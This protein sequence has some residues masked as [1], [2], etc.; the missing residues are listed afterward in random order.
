ME[1][2]VWKFCDRP[3]KPS[4]LAVAVSENKIVGLSSNTFQKIKVG[5]NLY[6]A[7][8]GTDAAVEPEYRR[9]G[10]MKKTMAL[11]DQ[12]RKDIG[13]A[14]TW[15]FTSNPILINMY[16]KEGRCTYPEKIVQLNRI[17]DVDKHVKNRG[18]K[19]PMLYSLGISTLK[20]I[21]SLFNFR[22]NHKTSDVRIASLDKFDDRYNQFW[23]KVKLQYNFIVERRSE[24][25][26]WR[27]MDPRGGD[28][29]V[30][31]ACRG[32]EILGYCVSR[33]DQKN[34]DYPEGFIVDFLCKPSY[35][36]AS[37]LLLD[38]AINYF[39]ENDVNN[40]KSLIVN[41]HPYVKL[42]LSRGFLASGADIFIDLR[43]WDIDE[44]WAL[45]MKS[46]NEKLFFQ[47]G[48]TDYI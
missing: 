45:F 4:L 47:Y 28:Y 30:R 25:M 36:C 32:D 8:T 48:D 44:D 12:V 37:K 20:I 41:G 16:K 10:I 9:K 13:V 26:N 6:Q 33:I 29:R 17:K 46:T 2:L 23:D 18:W 31:V 34:L 24:Y 38:D 14:M 22:R 40:V 42:F 35:D 39:D 19:Y 5:E 15:S 7:S 3:G 11:R 43:N 27:Y 1:H 21:N